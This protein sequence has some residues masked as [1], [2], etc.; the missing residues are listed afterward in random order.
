MCIGAILFIIFCF[1][2]AIPISKSHN[3][4]VVP[5]NYA[6]IQDAIDNASPHDVICV[7]GGIYEEHLVIDKP[8]YI[9]GSEANTPMIKI[10]ED[11]DIIKITASNVTISN[12]KI[13]KNLA[14]S[15]KSAGVVLSNVSFC[16]ISNNTIIGNFVGVLI[17]GG[18]FNLVQDNSITNNRYG[19]FLRRY[20]H[21]EPSYS[22]VI[23]RNN[24]SVNSWNGIEIDW[25]SGNL[26]YANTLL[27]NAAF[28][29]EIPDYTP[30]SSNVI[31]HNNFI[32]NA[33]VF[34][35][36]YQAYAPSSNYWNF[37]YE[38]NYWSD[39]CGVDENNDAISDVSYKVNNNV[40][41]YFPLMGIFQT[42][43]VSDSYVNTVTNASIIGFQH[44][45]M[46]STGQHT[47]LEFNVTSVA[48]WFCRVTIPKSLE[49]SFLALKINDHAT[50]CQVIENDFYINLY[51]I[52]PPGD[53]I[54]RIETLFIGEF[55]SGMYLMLF[56][57]V[58]FM[59][60]FWR[61]LQCHVKA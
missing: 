29:L 22:N 46:N 7:N 38:G 40:I 48:Q 50:E 37:S 14:G 19:V 8:L 20:Q 45:S 4:I 11:S 24:I 43:K 16:S 39:F 35:E 26:V 25:G 15:S 31:F 54:V 53:Y 5:E 18:A 33:R 49:L 60:L 59:V 3:E 61:R 47:F 30:S 17:E 10:C 13:V 41:D 32:D 34:G 52:Y 6:R 1:F 51:V 42:Y 57:I 23:C 36:L 56:M 44:Y 21:S 58:S 28:G 9:Y 12:L 2:S 55:Y 27:S